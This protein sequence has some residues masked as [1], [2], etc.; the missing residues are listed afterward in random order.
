MTGIYRLHNKAHQ[1]A[2]ALL[3]GVLTLLVGW[4]C[5]VGSNTAQHT[6][7]TQGMNGSCANCHLDG[8]ASVLLKIDEEKD[9]IEPTPPPFWVRPIVPLASLYNLIPI[10]FLGYLI[11]RH[12][13]H[14]T[15]Q[16]RF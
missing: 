9:D 12:K 13:I 15:T 16:M 14:L 8:Q 3:I 2:S 6:T 5:L 11:L 1:V 4:F 7:Q 10:T